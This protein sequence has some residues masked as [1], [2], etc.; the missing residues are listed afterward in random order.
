MGKAQIES[1]TRVVNIKY[2][3]A[4]VYIG[5][6]SPFGNPFTHLPL[7]KTQAQYQCA[8]RTESVILCEGWVFTQPGI[9]ALIDTLRDKALGCHCAP[10]LC[11]GS[12]YV[13]L[14][15]TY[16]AMRELGIEPNW[17]TTDGITL[18]RLHYDTIK[19]QGN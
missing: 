3:N 17:K 6:G 12:I 7:G 11:H 1:L 15:K 19:K 8:T 13:R 14:V 18:I 16:D 10:L 5:R 9:L 4:D 2:E